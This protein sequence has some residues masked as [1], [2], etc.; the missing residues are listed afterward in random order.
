MA[1]ETQKAAWNGAFN[2][3]GKAWELVRANPEPALVVVGA[4]LVLAVIQMSTSG[5][6]V[7]SLHDARRM[8]SW[9]LLFTLLFLLAIPTYALALA[10]G[11]KLSISEFMRFDAK[12]Y[13]ALLGAFILYG[14]AVAGSLLLLIIPAIWVIAWFAFYQMAIVDKDMGAVEGLKESKRLA[15][16]HKGKVWGIIGVLLLL[17]I[18]SGLLAVVPLIG[19]L[20]VTAASTTVGLLGAVSLALLYRWVQGHPSE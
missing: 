10:S 6:V 12:K 9:Q 18:G 2:A 4:S 17:S 20:L 3:F 19:N 11:K 14:L 7:E 5:V 1:R 16:D 15:K 13:F 8:G